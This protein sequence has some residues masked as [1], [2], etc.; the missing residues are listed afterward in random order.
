MISLHR[1]QGTGV[2]NGFPAKC[3]ARL[4]RT[5]L[6]IAL[7][8]STVPDPTW[9]CRTTFGA[10]RKRGLRFA[11]K[12]IQ[13][14]PGNP[15]AFQRMKKRG[16]IH[17]RR[18]TDIDQC[19]VRPQGLQDLVIDDVARVVGC[20]KRDEQMVRPAGQVDRIRDVGPGVGGGFLLARG[21]GDL[22]PETLQSLGN[23]RADPS[24][25]K[26]SG[27]RSRNLARQREHPLFGPGTGSD[28]VLRRPHAPH[29]RQQH[30]HG[31]VG[32]VVGQD[33][34]RVADPDP[35]RTAAWQMD[36]VIPD[37]EDADHLQLW[38]SRDHGLAG[39]QI[40]ARS[41]RVDQRPDIGKKRRLV[42]GLPPAMD[43]IGFVKRALVPFR[44][45][46]DLQDMRFCHG[47]SCGNA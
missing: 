11:L 32:H 30:R 24:Q 27:P 34:R 6:P 5:S 13:R 14:C 35:A 15:M 22:D 21:I 41:N 19:A 23:R 36:G 28:P 4:S 2:S 46:T 47:R 7:R 16:F 3:A 26:N 37:P 39:T 44:V 38:A 10:D 1:H 29:Q 18:P 17:V 31:N 9:G 42:I 45:G 33:I 25:P 8:V 40:P 43:D 20:G 12:N